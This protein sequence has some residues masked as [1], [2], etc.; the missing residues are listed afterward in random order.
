MSDTAQQAEW[1]E[2]G[3]AATEFESARRRLG[4]ALWRT[5]LPIEPAMRLVELAADIVAPRFSLQEG[6]VTSEFEGEAGMNTA[7]ACELAI[8]ARLCLRAMLDA[9]DR[10]D[11]A[12]LRLCVHGRTGA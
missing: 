10:A 3:A 7:R 6:I 9:A 2:I 1:S 12:A 5:D 8:Q 11:S 4:V